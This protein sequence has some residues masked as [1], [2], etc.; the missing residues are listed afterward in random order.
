MR[1]L[2]DNLSSNE[3]TADTLTVTPLAIIPSPIIQSN[4]VTGSSKAMP[5]L[6]D[7][8]DKLIDLWVSYLPSKIPGLARLAKERLVRS[9]AAELCFS[10]LAV[11]MR[12][13]SVVRTKPMEPREGTDFVLPVRT[14]PDLFEQIDKTPAQTPSSVPISSLPTP[15]A[16][17]SLPSGGNASFGECAEDEAIMRL[18]G[19]VLS[20]SSQPPLSAPRSAILS[21]WPS[22]PGADPSKY[23]WEA[24]CKADTEGDDLDSDE[25]EALNRQ[26]DQGRR[27]RRTEKFLKRHRVNTI[28]TASQP[29]PTVSF[30]SQ[31]ELSQH[32]LSSQP[33]DLPM[34]QPDRG[35]FG[36][37]LGQKAFKK[38]RTVGF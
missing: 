20:I 35:A 12:D 2:I 32:T 21:H 10:S 33:T 29:M 17:P 5:D 7:V 22:A 26:R 19:F 14:K 6:S 1:E 8:Y 37:R 24:S 4:I 38:R 23:S 28:D 27:D 11:S 3:E 15:A 25:N 31:P 16:T 34:T 18:R 36:S 9:V 30:G 13:K